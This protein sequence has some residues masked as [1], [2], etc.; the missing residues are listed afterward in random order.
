[1]AMLATPLRHLATTA[2]P[3]YTHGQ[4]NHLP[5][6]VTP[7]LLR[8][9]SFQRS[10]P[11]AIC[12]LWL[13]RLAFFRFSALLPARSPIKGR[14]LSGTAL[15]KLHCR[16]LLP[17]ANCPLPANKWI[18]KVCRRRLQLL[19]RDCRLGQDPSPCRNKST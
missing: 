2:L 1:L 17:A 4:L 8:S 14:K 3:V 12:L 19:L 7:S 6:S 5:S 18:S 15:G 10:S 16:G 9:C 11:P 13:W